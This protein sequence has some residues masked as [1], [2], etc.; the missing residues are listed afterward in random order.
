MLCRA[1]IIIIS[2]YLSRDANGQNLPDPKDSSA[3]HF[4][5]FVGTYTLGSP[6]SGIYVFT[7]DAANGTVK[8]IASAKKVTNP[9]FL[10][11][12]E[13]GS[14]VYACTESKL[15]NAGSVSSFYFDRNARSL[16]FLSKQ[17][18]MGENPVYV[19]LYKNNKWLVEG[20]YTA[21]NIAVFPIDAEHKLEPATQ[22][23]YFKDSSLVKD[24]QSASHPHATIF[25]P[26]FKYVLVTDLGGDKIKSYK[27]KSGTKE[28]LKLHKQFNC[29]PGSGPRHLTFHP[30]GKYCYSIEELSE[31]VSVYN[32]KNGSLSAIQRISTR[33][34]LPHISHGSAD[35]HISPDG[36]YLYASNRGD[37]NTITIYSIAED[38]KLILRGYQPTLGEHPRNF[39]IDPSGRFLLVANLAS[40]NIVVF[41]RDLESGLLSETG[42][43]IS[44]PHPSCLVFRKP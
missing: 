26:D 22:V 8:N 3:T 9:S 34:S 27:I 19:S 32:Y 23:L 28:P 5:L 4:Y 7:F 37:K 21:G 6:D 43:S 30:D 20:N 40:N 18:S 16:T 24:R 14:Y 42:I 29:I 35:I 2:L 11:V 36:K 10:T 44:I 17:S 25:S 39:A 33:D 15:K 31:M 41:K 12:S 38:G 1:L 13:D